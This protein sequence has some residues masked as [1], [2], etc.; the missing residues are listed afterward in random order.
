M[1]GIKAVG[2]ILM[3]AFTILPAATVGWFSRTFSSMVL[4]S[5]LVGAL[6]GAIGAYVSICLGKV[7]TGP[8]VVLILFTCFLVS[9]SARVALRKKGVLA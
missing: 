6:S 7:P 8:V 1:S 4:R 5:A 3:V 2:M 9:L